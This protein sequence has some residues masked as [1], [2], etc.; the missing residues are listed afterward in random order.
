VSVPVQCAETTETAGLRMG[1]AAR[2]GKMATVGRGPN[3]A[4]KLSVWDAIP[5]LLFDVCSLAR[6]P[7]DCLPGGL[8][9][10]PRSVDAV[11]NLTAPVFV[12][13]SRGLLR[14]TSRRYHVGAASV[15]PSF[16]NHA[17]PRYCPGCGRTAWRLLSGQCDS[18][19]QDSLGMCSQDPQPT[20]VMASNASSLPRIVFAVQKAPTLPTSATRPQS[21]TC[22]A[23]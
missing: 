14:V 23:A 3:L 12:H 21:S 20:P 4:P 7:N 8:S 22:G 10:P 5:P 6:R 13:V 1:K 16:Q 9:L 19:H 11:M 17:A 18:Q 15:A 2:A